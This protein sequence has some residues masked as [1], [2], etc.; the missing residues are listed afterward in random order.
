MQI[1]LHPSRLLSLR[2]WRVR[3]NPNEVRAGS[4]SGTLDN[5][6]GDLS[7]TDVVTAGNAV[8]RKSFVVSENPVFHE[9]HGSFVPCAAGANLRAVAPL[10]KCRI[11]GAELPGEQRVAILILN[12]GPT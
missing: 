10:R 6:L 12:A 3:V 9:R 8:V 1:W 7:P 11:L 2:E 4:N 5:C